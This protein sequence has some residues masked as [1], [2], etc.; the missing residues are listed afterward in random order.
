MTAAGITGDQLKNVDLSVQDAVSGD[1]SDLMTD[2]SRSR[3]QDLSYFQEKFLE[4][5]CAA[6]LSTPALR[7]RAVSEEI[8]RALFPDVD[9]FVFAGFF[10]LNNTEQ[11]LIRRMLDWE[12]FTLLLHR[13]KGIEDVLGKLGIETEAEAR[14]ERRAAVR[15]E[16]TFTKC[17]D[18]HG[19]VFAL[20]AVLRE[21]LAD[22]TRLH[23]R[24]VVV[25]P[26]SETLFPLYQQTLADL[27]QDQFNISLGYPLT[28]TP[29]FTFFERLF[30]GPPDGRRGRAGLRP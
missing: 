12:D 19:Q 15:P 16:I 18:T 1:G 17:P 28:R 22:P 7:L 30:A 5:V 29:I 4:A 11:D 23:E 27:A 2:R 26:A 24:Q 20:N 6:G 9:R 21:K 13:A 14:K 3:L 8:D 25:L 10:S